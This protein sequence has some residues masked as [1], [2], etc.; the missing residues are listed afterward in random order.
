MPLLF[1]SV[2]RTAGFPDNVSCY[3]DIIAAHGDDQVIKGLMSLA[4]SRTDQYDTLRLKGIRRDS[5]C[6]RAASLSRPDCPIEALFVPGRSHACALIDLTLGYEGYRKTWSRNF[7]HNMNRVSNKARR[8]GFLVRE[9]TPSDIPPRHL[10][11]EFLLLHLSR[12]RE[13][14]VFIDL[15]SFFEKLYPILFAERRMRVFALFRHDQIVGMHLSMV[16]YKRLFGWN[17]GFLPD[18]HSWA[19]GRLL[20]DEEVRQACA[21][22]LEEFDFWVEYETAYKADWKTGVHQIGWL[23]FNTS[24]RRLL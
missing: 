22:G 2:L 5:N 6:L 14:S 18:V 15:E 3:Q 12:F 4:I 19:P 17:G 8:D 13:D 9:L 23:E 16:G 1:D 21:E 10:P 24:T 7:R 20:F 11:D